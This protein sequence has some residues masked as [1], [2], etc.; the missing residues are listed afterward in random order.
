MKTIQRR[1]SILLQEE[2]ERTPVI[3]LLGPRQSGKTTLARMVFVDHIYVSL[4]ELDMRQYAKSD[5]R[6]FLQQYHDSPGVIID[7]VQHVPELLSY[8]QTQV[9]LHRKP[10]HFIITG[11]HNFLLLQAIT[12]SLAGRIA[13]H[14]LLPLSVDELQEAQLL[15][16]HENTVLFQGYYPILYGQENQKPE[17]WYR[18]YIQTYIERDVRMITA[19]KDLSL[20]QKFL[21]LCAGR[22]GQLLNYAALANDVG[23]DQKTVKQWISILEASYIVYLLKPY[24]NNFNKQL[25]KTPKLYFYDTGLACSLLGITSQ[26]QLHT[27]YARGALFE[28]MVI[29]ELFKEQYNSNQ[30]PYIYFWRDKTGHEI[31]ALL[32]IEQKKYAIEIKA[33][34]TVNS[35]FFKNLSWFQEQAGNNKFT[36]LVIFAGLQE[37]KRS[38]AQVINWKKCTALF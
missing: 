20:F 29:T 28:S 10:G 11:S 36:N 3:A 17:L 5:P 18:N 37:Q 34:H 24:H 38:I 13:L 31:D 6:S 30:F 22:I 14:T 23:V 9:D 4:E 12:Q 16:E 1:L 2:A 32:E 27:Y 33:G 7:E 21:Q 8:M 35:D 15:P 19:V 26:E 25:L